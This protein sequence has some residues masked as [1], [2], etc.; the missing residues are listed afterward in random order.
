MTDPTLQAIADTMR[1]THKLTGLP[2]RSRIYDL[3]I[4]VNPQGT[5]SIGHINKKGQVPD[6]LVYTAS[7]KE[8]LQAALTYLIEIAHER[9][10]L[11]QEGT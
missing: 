2:L 8:E 3:R 10:V 1:S 9:A 6:S 4:S 7:D 11:A 5:S